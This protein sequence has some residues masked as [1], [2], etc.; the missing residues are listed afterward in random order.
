MERAKG[1]E[2]STPTLARSCST[3]ELHPRFQPLGRRYTTGG[4]QSKLQARS[5][6]SPKEA[7]QRVFAPKLGTKSN[8]CNG[9][10]VPRRVTLI[11]INPSPGRHARRWPNPSGIHIAE[12]AIARQHVGLAR[13]EREILAI[14]IN[15]ARAEVDKRTPGPFHSASRTGVKCQERSKGTGKMRMIFTSIGSPRILTQRSLD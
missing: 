7:F 11:A 5:S 13:L 3:P 6:S 8:L 9:A 2:P 14:F 12:A 15:I 10:A 1:F 4:R